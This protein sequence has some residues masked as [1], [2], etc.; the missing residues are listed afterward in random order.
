MIL[1]II[2]YC[3]TVQHFSMSISMILIQK[4]DWMRDGCMDIYLYKLYK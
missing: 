3:K 4:D 1:V 2:I